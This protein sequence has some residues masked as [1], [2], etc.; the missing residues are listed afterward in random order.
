VCPLTPADH[1]RK[2]VARDLVAETRGPDRRLAVIGKR[3]H[4]TVTALGSRLSHTVDV[5]PIIA[6]RLVAAPDGPRASPP[7]R[8]SPAT[9]A[10]RRS[11][12]PAESTPTSAVA[13]VMLTDEQAR[14]QPGLQ[15]I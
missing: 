8:I 12:S 10:R 1:T 5:G 14:Q 6:G 4:D 15:T 2:Q 7:R 3:L 9:P 11:R 13:P